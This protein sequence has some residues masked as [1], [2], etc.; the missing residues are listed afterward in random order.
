VDDAELIRRIQQGKLQ[1]LT[2]LI[3]RHYASL[4]KYCYWKIRNTEEAQDITQETF[5]RFCRNIEQYTHSGKCRAYL[6]TIARNLCHNYFQDKRLL[7]LE[8]VREEQCGLT[9][10]MEEKIDSEQLVYELITGLPA[11]QRE[12]LFLR[13]C[14]DLKFRE[15]AEITGTNICMV[16]Y[17]VKRGLNLLRKKYE[18]EENNEETRKRPDP[19]YA[20]KVPCPP[21]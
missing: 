14:L 21:H 9:A 15:I 13:F 5:Y 11:E 8:E 16:Q 6:Y 17:R 4:Q 19:D 1:Y 2:P 20:Q 18:M 10:T 3:E 12:A 7:S